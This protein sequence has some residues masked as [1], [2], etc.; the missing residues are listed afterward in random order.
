[1][2]VVVVPV[3]VVCV[4][5]VV[6][7]ARLRISHGSAVRLKASSMSSPYPFAYTASWK[8]TYLQGDTPRST[9]VPCLSNKPTCPQNG[10]RVLVSAAAK[11]QPSP[12]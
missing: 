11:R 10:L 6:V 4:G 9:S 7:L 1:M 3:V 5:G 8:L 2:V 12:S